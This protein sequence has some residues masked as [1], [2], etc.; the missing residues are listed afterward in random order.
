M[1]VMKKDSIEIEERII[2][3]LME[4][5]IEIQTILVDHPLYSLQ[6]FENISNQLIKCS[7][8]Y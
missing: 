3:E 1:V 5:L 7:T 4:K 2:I 6:K 8:Y